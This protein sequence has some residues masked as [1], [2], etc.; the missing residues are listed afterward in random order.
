MADQTKDKGEGVETT[1]G[2]QNPS[3]ED[4]LNQL[5]LQGEEEDDLDLSGEL[6]DLVK[7]VRWLALFR[8]HTSKPFS[9]AALF[10]A[11]RNAWLAAKEVNFKVL[12]PNLFLV[13]LHCLGDWGRVMEGS[14][15]LFRGAAVVMQEYDGFSNVLA[16]KLDKIPV[17]ARIQGIPEGLMK[18]RELAK[19]VAKKVGDPIVVMVNEGRINP[20]PY[21]RTRVWL[22]LN[23][24][25]VRVVPITLKER[26][27]YL[28]Q[29]EK[30]PSFCFYC[31]CIGHEVTECGDGTH[32]KQSCQWG[33]WL[34]VPFAP[35]SGR[36]DQRGGR[37]GGRGRGRGRSG[38]RG[39][40]YHDDE[41]TDIV[42][43]E[44]Q[45]H[46]KALVL[47]KGLMEEDGSGRVAMQVNRFE[48]PS[49]VDPD[50]SPLKEQ[51]KKRPRRNG[52]EVESAVKTTNIKSALSFE[53]SDRE[54]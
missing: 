37:G 7:E 48:Q 49:Q 4:C 6:E 18:K 36:E 23:K 2:F 16:Y 12:E 32:E 17:W 19:K 53:E 26:I 14:P 21:L 50:I 11:L 40:G 27:Q 25:L 44:E 45:D 24:P 5:N 29:Y 3:L 41:L 38:G 15:W 33:D 42:M 30:L 28:V 54:Q 51:D 9:H 22:D 13:Q 52:G 20:T 34:R 43:E 39:E 31:G 35:L 8:V 1:E 47:K 46:G 10:S